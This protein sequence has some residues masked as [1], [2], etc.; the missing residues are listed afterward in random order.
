MYSIQFIAITLKSQKNEYTYLMLYRDP[1]ITQK[2]GNRTQNVLDKSILEAIHIRNPT[3]QSTNPIGILENVRC[4]RYRLNT[5]LQS[6][7]D[8]FN[9]NMFNKLIIYVWGF[10]WQ[11]KFKECSCNKSKRAGCLIVL[12]E[13][14]RSV[15]MHNER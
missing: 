4:G 2:Y 9:N 1:A 13:S 7:P 6:I 10:R 11:R 14:F 12:L 8:M 15:R 3:G 5:I